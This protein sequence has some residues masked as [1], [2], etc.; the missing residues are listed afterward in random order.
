MLWF[1]DF[2]SYNSTIKY[3]EKDFYCMCEFQLRYYKTRKM[4]WRNSKDSVFSLIV[5]MSP[6]LTIHVFKK[7]YFEK[8]HHLC[9][10]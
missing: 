2:T 4:L 1:V 6:I 8:Y 10:L 7:Y 3:R 5:S 9:C